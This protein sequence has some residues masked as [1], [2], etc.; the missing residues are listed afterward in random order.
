MGCRDETVLCIVF[1]RKQLPVFYFLREA[2]TP[3]KLIEKDGFFP[4][5]R[6]PVK[7]F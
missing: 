4:T 2:G 1:N 7:G 6:K 3:V 5:R